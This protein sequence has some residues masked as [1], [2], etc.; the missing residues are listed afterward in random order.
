MAQGQT[1]SWTQTCCTIFVIFPIFVWRKDE[2]Q[3]YL[4]LLYPYRNLLYPY[5]NLRYPTANCC[6]KLLQQ[7]TSKVLYCHDEC[8]C[9]CTCDSSVTSYLTSYFVASGPPRFAYYW[10]AL[11]KQ[12]C[13]RSPSSLWDIYRGARLDR[14]KTTPSLRSLRSS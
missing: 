4:N 13:K 2:K 10:S 1:A 11:E 5:R 9:Y 8:C 6:S 12:I 14:V 7:I 3:V